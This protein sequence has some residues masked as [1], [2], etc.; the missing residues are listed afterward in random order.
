MINLTLTVKTI[1]SLFLLLALAVV[2]HAQAPAPAEPAEEDEDAPPPA[3][4]PGTPAPVK[5]ADAPPAEPPP[6]DPVLV[7]P[8][9]NPAA[10]ASATR[11]PG[12]IPAFPS[13][14]P[15]ALV[16]S[17]VAAAMWAKGLT[18]QAK[19][20][21]NRAFA[22]TNTVLTPTAMSPAARTATA[23]PT[24]SATAATPAP[25]PGAARTNAPTLARP[26]AVTPP[27]TNVAVP[28][29]TPQVPAPNVAGAVAP[30]ANGA[31]VPAAAAPKPP[32]TNDPANDII[33]SSNLKFQDADLIQ[34]LDI[35]Q[36]LTG[37]T[38]LRPTS[39]PAT[40]IQL[41]CAGD[42][43]RREAVLALDSILSMN[44]I[45]MVPQ[46]E[47]FVKA[48]AQAQA[49]Q[50]ANRFFT[51]K[52]EEL[53]EAGTL[54]TYIAQLKHAVPQDVGQLLQQ[55][56]KM[57]GNSIVAFP[58]TSTLLIRDYA[59]N[60]KRMVEV[61]E[62]IDV[63]VPTEY[64]SIVIPIKYALATDIANVISGLATGGGG[65]T[66]GTSRPSTGLSGTGAGG[67]GGGG[68]GGGFGGMG[69]VGGMM[70]QQ[71][72]NQ[73]G[74]FGTT[75]GLGS[76]TGLGG[77][78]AGGGRASFSDRLKN[79]VS[80]AA[81]A[82]SG[83]IVV[84]GQTKIF[85]DE[86]TN[87]L[88]IYASKEDI[89][90]IKDII[91]KLDVVLAQVL[92]EALIFEVSLNDSLSYGFSY[93]Q[94]NLT[95]SGDKFAGIGAINN[96]PFLRAAQFQQLGTNSSVPGGFSYVANI[97]DKFTMTAQ[98][99]AGNSK[100]NIL[101]RPRVQTSHAVE[102][103]LFVG[104]T[105]PYPTGSS[106]GGVYGGYSQ[107]QQLQIGITLSVLPLI[108]PDGLVV[109]DIRQKIQSVGGEVEIANVGKVPAT[110]DR[111]ANAKVAVKDK[112]TIVLG[113]FIS[114]EKRKSAS[115]VPILKDIP[116]IGPL[117]RSSSS[118]GDRKELMIMIRPTVLPNPS[119]AALMAEDEKARM[120]SVDELAR[121]SQWSDE[122]NEAKTRKA[123]IKHQQ[124]T[125]KSDKT[126]QELLKRE[127]LPQD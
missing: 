24:P 31:A 59:E 122:K 71:G 21:T 95:Q 75:R 25:S 12:T 13:R 74:Q 121:E 115:G 30:P 99:L 72:Y 26:T 8:T 66:I 123:R 9:A 125:G 44:G 53:P 10:P 3:A 104:E 92:I 33:A 23:T 20:L 78:Q 69:G 107:I 47:K 101:Q 58:N 77:T 46:G 88:L 38:V 27:A 124:D 73:G 34:V 65:T 108:N 29:A 89:A 109:M 111:E 4:T 76:T 80:K 96:I 32:G 119:D 28:A 106:Y 84:L 52:A 103:N 15:N 118:S 63:A 62:K 39:L 126:R 2:L 94:N 7:P 1:T 90:T 70:G 120:P 14:P 100:V 55:F 60:V 117:F 87:S 98:A 83:E 113:G 36:E 16:L 116:L 56:A 18:N 64:E 19:A 102:A 112:E 6:G 11:P 110:I 93:A 54:V 85:P 50:E 114:N 91:S 67:F 82:A 5:P 79:I 48:V 81:A 37:R 51:G 61:I 35:Y 45:T 22:D 86:R 57:P 42:L 43:T 49:N 105:R 97:Q 40:K 68:M 17:N 127:G 41:K